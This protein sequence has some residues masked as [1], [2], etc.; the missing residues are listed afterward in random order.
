M[1]TRRP[2]LILCAATLLLAVLSTGHAAAQSKK[3][4]STVRFYPAPGT[5]NYIGLLGAEVGKHRQA[6]YGV[7][8]D[9]SQ[10]TLEVGDPCDG[11]KNKLGPCQNDATAF[12]NRTALAWLSASVTIKNRTQF[13]FQLPLGVTDTEQ[14][15]TSVQAGSGNPTL[16]I[17]P[18]QGFGLGDARFLAKTHIWHTRNDEVRFAAAVFTTLPTAMLTSRGDCRDPHECMFLGERGV[19]A[20]GFGI[21][22]FAR[23]DFRGAVNVGGQYRPHRT[24]LTTETGSEILYGVAGMYAFTPLVNGKAEVV[25]AASIRARDYP[26]EGRAQ[27]GLGDDLVFNVGAAAGMVGVVGN[28]SFRVFAGAQWTPITRD[29][30][31]DGIDDRV[32]ACPTEPEDRDGFMDDDGCP[33]PDN[34]GDGI[35]DDKDACIDER[36]D[37]DGFA[38]D[39]GCPDPD[40]DGDGVPDGYDSC[41]GEMEDMD[42]DRDD[43]GCPDADED[44]DGIDDHLDM[45]PNEPEDHDNLGDDDGCPEDDYDGDG[46]ADVDDACPDAAE[47]WN[48][49]LDEDGCPEDDEDADGVPDQIDQC[50]DQAETLN[51]KNDQ[52]GCPDGPMLMV[53]QGQRLLPTATPAF[54]GDTLRGQSFLVD[55]VA[56][57]VKHNH[58]RGTVHVVLVAPADDPRAAARAQGLAAALQKRS[59]RTVTSAHFP[60]TPMR[61]EIE[62]VPPGLS[63]LPRAL[64]PPP[65]VP[66]PA[67]APEPA[68]APPSDTPP[69]PPAPP[70]K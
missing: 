37:F 4:F 2:S 64:P 26:L 49:I 14:F 44:R 6:S 29:R 3:D 27:I 50:P 68:P 66:A 33:D 24:F 63:A 25:G 12:V 16:V 28:P 41:E 47:S 43:D 5:G 70:S 51:G 1:I 23:G 20:G 21:V 9:Y 36:E 22:E 59:G 18:R 62:L 32:D 31:N 60:G 48:D 42:G 39:D 40:N 53:F 57:Y 45:C 52:D 8:L 30:D 69:A 46:I 65:A 11:I 34:D 17:Q 38:D 19:Q 58:K 13:S 54:E 55:A 56:N 61:F 67:A 15:S 35:P 10:N 7:M